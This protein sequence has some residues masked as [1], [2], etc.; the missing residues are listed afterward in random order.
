MKLDQPNPGNVPGTLKEMLRKLSSNSPILGAAIFSIEGLPLV[1]YFHGS[2]EEVAVAAMVAGIYSAGEAT[3]KELR[4]GD[5]KSIIVEGEMGMT[6]IISMHGGYLLAV[7]AP[8][9]ARLG[10]V[11]NDSKRMARQAAKVLQDL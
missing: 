6:V 2:T 1:S 11:Y 9:N 8:E 7:T 3:V 5:L 4:Q 10:L